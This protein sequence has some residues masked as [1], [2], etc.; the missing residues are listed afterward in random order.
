MNVIKNDEADQDS[1]IYLDKKYALVRQ[2]G[3]GGFGGIFLA[4]DTIEK[5]F[6]A[7]KMN[8]MEETEEIER[9]IDLMN[10]FDHPNILSIDDYSI[11]KGIMQQGNG[12]V[13]SETVSYMVMPFASYGDLSSYLRGDSYF[14]EDIAVY[15]FQQMFYGLCHIHDKGYV[16]LDIKPDNILITKE[17]QVKIA[18]FGLSLPSKGEDDKGVFNKRRWGTKTF[19]SPEIALGFEYNGEQADLYALAI[20]LFI[21]IFG[22]RPFREI[23]IDDPLF[24][25]LLKEPLAFWMAHPVT[26]NRIKERSVSE[27][28]VDLLARMLAVNPDDRITKNEIAKHVWM[29]KF[30]KDVY[31]ENDYEQFEFAPEILDEE[32]DSD[33]VVNEEDELKSSESEDV[34]LKSESDRSQIDEQV[35]DLLEINLIPKKSFLEKVSQVLKNIKANSK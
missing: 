33:Y 7:I 18:D 12:S 2:I 25:K 28:V 20:I 13:V 6:K 17:M 14:D 27:E 29:T 32:N 8:R 9:E 31:E 5:K 11:K 23:K 22:C 3:E 19:W 1:F 4:Q 16:H 15:W 30:S 21:M 34:S 24:M 10:H 35:A 26:R